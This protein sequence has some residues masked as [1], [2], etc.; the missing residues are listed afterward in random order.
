M[1]TLT[2]GSDNDFVIVTAVTPGPLP[3]AAT[4]RQRTLGKSVMSEA[5]TIWHAMETRRSAAAEP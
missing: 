1:A 4:C 5:R 2:T 3:Q